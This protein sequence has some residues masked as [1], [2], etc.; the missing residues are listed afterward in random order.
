[1]RVTEV[2]GPGR[3]ERLGKGVSAHCE[4]V[5]SA[6]NAQRR[7]SS[8]K[9]YSLLNI[10]HGLA[11]GEERESGRVVRGGLG[12]GDDVRAVGHDVRV[13]AELREGE[14]DELEVVDEL[15]LVVDEGLP[16]AGGARVASDQ[17]VGLET[18]LT[19]KRGGDFTL[20]VGT[21][22]G[23]ISLRSRTD[24]GVPTQ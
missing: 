10:S 9:T 15:G 17:E 8:A 2:S 23:T 20:V 11:S 16:L 7:Q 12:D 14:E 13:L 21:A 4:V 19:G 3:L 5:L 24:N 1:M 22:A 6:S 18:H